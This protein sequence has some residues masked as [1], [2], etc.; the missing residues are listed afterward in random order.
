MRP[1]TGGSGVSHR[2][3]FWTIVALIGALVLAVV[4][5]LADFPLASLV[6]SGMVTTILI[7]G[8]YWID[9][10]RHPDEAGSP[11]AAA[12]PTR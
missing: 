3:I 5:A 10:C 4:A 1:F 2:A 9:R 7:V 8:M 11:P 12:I 6:V